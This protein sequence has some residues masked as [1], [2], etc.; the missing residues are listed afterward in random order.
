MKKL[1]GIFLAA[2]LCMM[3]A[4]AASAADVYVTDG[5]TGDGSSSA[6]PLGNMTEAI[7]K[8]GAAG[9]KVIIVGT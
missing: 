1:L 8:I 5:G 9:G 2:L 4:V 6:A 3:L 7:N